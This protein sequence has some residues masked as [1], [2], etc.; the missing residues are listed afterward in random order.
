MSF[1]SLTHAI[2]IN[3]LNRVKS[4]LDT[5]YDPKRIDSQD[6]LRVAVNCGYTEIAE[7]LLKAG[8]NPNIVDERSGWT[9]LFTARREA[10]I[11]I[12]RL[13]L[14]H[15]ADVNHED[16][17]GRHVLYF[18]VCDKNLAL[19]KFLLESG[20]KPE[21][22]G[23]E[24]PLFVAAQKNYEVA[25]LLIDHGADVNGRGEYGMTVLMNAAKEG[26]LDIVKALVENGA[27]INARDESGNTAFMVAASNNRLDIINYLH[28][29]GA[30][31]QAADNE[32]NNA[33]KSAIQSYRTGG[34]VK[35]LIE[36]G[37]DI[38]KINEKGN[39]PL[40]ISAM[41]KE[42]GAIKLLLD[43]HAKVDIQNHEGETALMK[44]CDKGSIEG[45]YLLLNAGANMALKNRDQEC[46]LQIAMQKYYKI[47]GKQDKIIKMLIKQGADINVLNQQGNT[48]LMSALMSRAYNLTIA[49]AFITAKTNYNHQNHKGETALLWAA[50]RGY[51]TQIKK[52]LK[53]P[54]NVD[55][56]DE[57]GN[58]ALMYA[59]K[60]KHEDVAE[61]L[62][63]SKHDL[64]VVNKNGNTP[65]IM[66]ISNKM[67]KELIIRIAEETSNLNAVNSN[68]K[69][70]LDL[71]IEQ[72]RNDLVAFIEFKLLQLTIQQGPDAI[73]GLGF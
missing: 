73:N 6:A 71:A 28:D 17:N 36:L 45:V 30:D 42:P 57:E 68:N 7:Y 24:T 58:T 67:D 61:L 47:E 11:E 35:L 9:P 53:Y 2:S 40:M 70:A 44:S 50:H 41:C 32:G 26:N 56:Q 22:H 66:A 27:D 5:G 23:M 29:Q 21:C 51:I 60:K 37:V 64:N 25:K 8:A 69:S 1:T 63:E 18:T 65:L 52:M 3:D 20:A 39:T 4:I 55:I 49:N 15:G 10:G 46:A 59:I 31:I 14:S 48:C 43:Q 34:A 13:L 12:T 62:L 72:D 19:T 16:Q 54:H 38:N 33:L